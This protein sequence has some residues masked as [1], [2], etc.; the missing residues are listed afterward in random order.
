MYLKKT[1]QLLLVVLVLSV[2]VGCSQGEPESAWKMI[3]SGAL[4]VDVRS[5]GEFN[6]GHLPD[7][8]LIPVGDVESRIAE[9]GD[10]KNRPIVVY[11]KAGVRAAKAIN[12][13]KEHGYTN[14]LNG[15]GYS[16]LM[17]SRP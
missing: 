6:Q 5:P 13:L 12:V 14:V 17:A 2:S 7:A 16:D 3:N 1:V 11:C 10:D 4:L 9:F 8:K 15:G